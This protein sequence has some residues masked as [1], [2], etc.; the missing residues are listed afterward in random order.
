MQGAMEGA[1]HRLSSHF[2]A[3]TAVDSPSDYFGPPG[4]TWLIRGRLAGMPQPGVSRGVESDLDALKR[5]NVAALISL[6]EEWAPPQELIRSFGIDS[7]H[8]PIADMGVPTVEQADAIC[9]VVDD[10]ITSGRSVTFHCRAGK[11]RT[12]TLLASQMLWYEPDHATAIHYVKAVNRAWIES[13]EQF[14]FLER[15]A[16]HRQ[17]VG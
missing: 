4:F 6:T 15:Y 12:G 7:I 14:A 10:I 17:D 16:R 8:M 11:G 1:E 13:G 5:M 9:Q 3:L 2:A